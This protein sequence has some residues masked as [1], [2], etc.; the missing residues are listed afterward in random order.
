[1]GWPNTKPSTDTGVRGGAAIGA[2]GAPTTWEGEKPRNP[3]KRGRI[4]PGLFPW[5]F[6]KTSL[7]RSSTIPDLQKTR[8]FFRLQ[9][10]GIFGT[11]A[12]NKIG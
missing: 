3:R 9:N 5:F 6:Q 10:L 8:T 2:P 7:E 4:T 11:E 1:M 12:G